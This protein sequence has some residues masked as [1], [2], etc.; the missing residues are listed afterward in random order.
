M[1]KLIDMDEKATAEARK[2]HYDNL[3]SMLRYCENKTDCRRVVQLQYFGEVFD[4][5]ICRNSDAPCDNC[6]NTNHVKQDVTQFA[7]QVVEGVI[8]ISSRPRFDQKNC[9]ANHVVRI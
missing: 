3:N 8:R 1:R 2:I 5:R 7:R 6:R 4:P 9:T